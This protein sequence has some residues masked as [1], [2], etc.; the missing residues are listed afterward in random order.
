MATL[1]LRFAVLLKTGI[2]LG[3]IGSCE[4]SLEH[5]A[6]TPAINTPTDRLQFSDLQGSQWIFFTGTSYPRQQAMEECEKISQYELKRWRLPTSEEMTNLRKNQAKDPGFAWMNGRKFWSI[7][8]SHRLVKTAIYVEGS[9]GHSKATIP[10]TRMTASCIH[11]RSSENQDT[12]VD[13]KTSNA[14]YFLPNRQNWNLGKQACQAKQEAEQLPWRL[15]TLV[16]L[17][18]AVVNGIQNSNNQA[19]GFENLGLTWTSKVESIAP[20]EAYAT[21][22]ST[23]NNYIF[24]KSNTLSVVCIRELTL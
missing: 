22:L 5:K 18:E 1:A 3:A 6:V 10:E 20:E 15:P 16:E 7:D 13:Q 23:K 2:I 24:S 9:S 12:W 17:K 8:R 4:T 14:W 19:F 21:N 11:P